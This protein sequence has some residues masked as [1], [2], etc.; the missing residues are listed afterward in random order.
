MAPKPAVTNSKTQTKWLRRFA[1][2]SMDTM[3]PDRIIR[4]PIVGVPFLVSRWDCGPSARIGWP[5]PCFKRKAEMIRGPKKKT[6]NSAVAA[7]PP[8]RTVM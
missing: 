4:P 1:H 7:A 5:L 3:S 6:K 2:S 8:V